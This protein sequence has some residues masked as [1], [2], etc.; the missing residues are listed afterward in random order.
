[1][2]IVATTIMNGG[3]GWAAILGTTAG[4]GAITTRQDRLGLGNP[5][6]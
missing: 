3:G 6:G 4:T 5:D 2:V 1:M